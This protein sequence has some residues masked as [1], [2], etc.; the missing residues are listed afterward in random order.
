[1]SNNTNG[2]SNSTCHLII[3]M[4][5]EQKLSSILELHQASPLKV[6]CTSPPGMVSMPSILQGSNTSQDQQLQ[7]ETVRFPFWSFASC[8]I[9]PTP[10]S[11]V[12]ISKA[13]NNTTKHSQILLIHITFCWPEVSIPNAQLTLQWAKFTKIST[14]K[15]WNPSVWQIYESPLAC[16]FSHGAKA[17]SLRCSKG[18]QQICNHQTPPILWPGCTFDDQLMTK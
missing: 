7:S 14:T 16:N 1:M 13:W 15:P 3:H 18:V 9:D 2:S 10:G 11:K 5:V 12:D 17:K 6:D 8:R 4:F